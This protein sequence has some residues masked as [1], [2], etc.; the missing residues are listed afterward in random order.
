MYLLRQPKFALTCT[1]PVTD[2]SS[3]TT[4]TEKPVALVRH[5]ASTPVTYV[6]RRR[7]AVTWQCAVVCSWWHPLDA[8]TCCLTLITPSSQFLSC[9][10]AFL[11]VFHKSSERGSC[12]QQ[13]CYCPLHWDWTAKQSKQACFQAW[14]F[15]INM[16]GCILYRQYVHLQIC[17]RIY[18]I[19]NAYNTIIRIILPTLDYIKME[20]Y[21]T[22]LYTY[23]YMYTCTTVYV[24]VTRIFGVF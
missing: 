9:F 16:Y 10:S 3:L 4:T 12:L 13:Q 5:L 20:I 1:I 6:S 19:N 7:V 2:F 18:T 22:C 23:M 14:R 8:R 15:H 17:V 11:S 21:C 24:L